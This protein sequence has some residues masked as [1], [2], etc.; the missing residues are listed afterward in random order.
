M[1][2][3]RRDEQ[4]V[5]CLYAAVLGRYRG[6]FYQRQEIALHALARYVA[7]DTAFSRAN[8]VDLVEEHDAVVFHSLD[9]FLYQP[10]LIEQLVGFL[11]DQDFV[12]FFDRH[13]PFF[14]AAAAQLA[15]DIAN[16]DG[17]HLGAR[18]PRYLEQRQAGSPGLRLDLDLLLVEFAGAQLFAEDL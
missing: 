9:G 4:D 12:G 2:G 15:E 7:A 13:A 18:H 8:L 3:A 11:V 1:E 17:A 14:G 6:A 10:V 5:V 16:R